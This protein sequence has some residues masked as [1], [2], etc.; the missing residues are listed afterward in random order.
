MNR[1]R[2][3]RLVGLLV[4][5]ICLSLATSSQAALLALW[6]F[7]NSTLV[8]A[9]GQG[10]QSATASLTTVGTVNFTV[11]AEGTALN[12]PRINPTATP[13]AQWGTQGGSFTIQVSGVNVG[14]FVITYAAE[15]NGNSG[16]QEWDYSLDGNTWTTLTTTL[17]ARPKFSTV[18]ADFSGITSL[19]GASTVY[20]R[21]TFD[22]DIKYDNIQ[23][24]INAV[25]EPIN[26]AVASFGVCMLVIGFGRRL[27]SK[28]RTSLISRF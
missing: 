17:K 26:V 16:N 3:S 13:A 10:S 18:T 6:S 25:P 9:I 7:D 4:T 8:P 22:S 23:V 11:P 12:D 19:N 2:L 20:F 1:E 28:L 15:K 21:D 24:S 5:T 27:Y 14:E